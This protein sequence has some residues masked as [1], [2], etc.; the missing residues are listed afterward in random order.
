MIKML[1]KLVVFCQLKSNTL[2]NFLL[3]YSAHNETINKI[4]IYSLNKVCF[5]CKIS[6]RIHLEFQIRCCCIFMHNYL[7]SGM[8]RCKAVI[9]ASPRPTK[10]L[11]HMNEQQVQ[12]GQ[13]LSK[14]I[15]SDPKR[16]VI[17]IS[18]DLSHM[19]DYECTE[20]YYTPDPSSNL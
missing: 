4:F 13:S 17:L 14:M 19:Y 10:R 11:D 3:S 2:C 8:E 18:G 20:D 6:C 9:M 1:M 12:I 16:I 7:D 15:A 5:I